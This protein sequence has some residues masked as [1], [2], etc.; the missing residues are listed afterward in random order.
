VTWVAATALLALLPELGFGQGFLQKL[1]VAC[2]LGLNAS[3]VC[4]A[5]GIAGE[6]NLGQVAVYAGGAYLTGWLSLNVTS[7]ILV[8]LVLSICLG[9]VIG[10]LTSL[11]AFRMSGWTLAM[12]SFFL[13]LLVPDIVQ[14][15]GNPLGGA[16]GLAAIPIPTIF[17]HPLGNDGL[18]VL[19]IVVT[20]LLFLLVRNLVH[21][22]F[23]D[24]LHVLKQSP[25]LSTSVGDS[26]GFLRFR[27]YALSA[28]AP[29]IG[30]CLF[31]YLTAYVSPTSFSLTLSITILAAAILGGA[32]SVY[33]AMIGAV[34]MEFGPEQS[35]TASKY[36]LVIYGAVL[37]L[38]GVLLA[39][40]LVS[41][42]RRYS[43]RVPG[44][45]SLE[46]WWSLERRPNLQAADV[47]S[48][49]LSGAALVVD[50]VSKAFGGNQALSGVSMTALAGQVTA[51]IG[52]NGSGKTTLLNLISGF[53][54]ADGGSIALG[55]T[56]LTS[57]GA[58]TVAR[59]GVARTFQTPQIPQGLNVMRVVETGR[60]VS[61]WPTMVESM[62]R[63]PRHWATVRH[64]RQAA[65]LA[66][67]LV[68]VGGLRNVRAGSLP[69]GTRRLVE[70]ARSLA[71]QP[72]VLLLDEVASGLDEEEIEALAILVRRLADGGMTIVIVEHNFGLVRA[73][74]DIS[75]V[76]A[77]GKVIAS[78][79]PAEVEA[80]PTVRATYFGTSDQSYAGKL[81]GGR[82]APVPTVNDAGA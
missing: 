56:A 41:V 75:Y 33:G 6:M 13:V 8:A 55:D 28:V 73:V 37:I 66:L 50:D 39:G 21:S 77:D 30:G 31:A 40:G 43:G 29:A 27:A 70:L 2:L 48:L 74:A 22:R 35:A 52:P 49:T 36:G 51:L 26:V 18:Y 78:G 42:I 16:V 57:Q 15:V 71:S 14:L 44:I 80:D 79:K 76:L 47:A 38:V 34:I 58:S 59:T 9:L 12:A 19:I 20:S 11:P 53:Y 62:L 60:H 63:L 82:A 61:G 3:S 54:D 24:A 46:R 32:G 5:F 23:G 64:D 17:G 4:L 68:G 10:V 67:D 7:D 25:V 1:S 69:L 65:Q 81:G 72:R 45:G